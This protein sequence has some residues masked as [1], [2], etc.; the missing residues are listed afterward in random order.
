MSL[1]F[2]LLDKAHYINID[3]VRSEK[4]LYPQRNPTYSFFSPLFT[5]N[6][7]VFSRNNYDFVR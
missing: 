4:N 6:I 2:T 3:L 7:E 1:R 5:V